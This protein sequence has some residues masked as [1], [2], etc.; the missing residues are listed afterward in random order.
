MSLM[1]EALEQRGTSPSTAQAASLAAASAP[2][3]GYGLNSPGAPHTVEGAAPAPLDEA[4]LAPTPRPR[5]QVLGAVALGIALLLSAGTAFWRGQTG[6]KAAAAPFTAVPALVA[7][8]AT[9]DVTDTATAATAALDAETAAAAT[10]SVTGKRISEVAIPPDAPKATPTAR[11]DPRAPLPGM[12][13]TPATPNAPARAPAGGNPTPASTGP[14]K[15]QLQR[16]VP[17]DSATAAW[18]KMAAGQHE[19]ALAQYRRV[20]ARQPDDIESLVGAASLLHRA[21]DREAAYQHYRR[22]LAIGPQH[23]GAMSGLLQLMGEADPA[24]AESRLKDFIETHAADDS[25]HAALGQLLAR[26]GRWSEAQGAFFQAHTQRP[27]RA[28]HAYNLAV[29]LDRLHHSKQAIE[30]YRLAT[31]LR[32][33]GDVPVAAARQRIEKLTAV[34]AG[35]AQAVNAATATATPEASAPAPNASWWKRLPPAQ[36]KPSAEEAMP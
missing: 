11:G 8:N 19:E 5:W 12:P 13:A 16:V 26:Q 9:A 6:P 7:E 33:P 29:A 15:L 32:S 14:D 35:P 24:T 22:A 27:E 21:G 23:A 34:L 17:A 10:T 31:T 3:A 28:S 1:L 4:P 36:T 30:F 20:L 25:A 18:Q 2:L